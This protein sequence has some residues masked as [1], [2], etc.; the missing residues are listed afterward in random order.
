MIFIFL[1][2]FMETVLSLIHTSI[3]LDLVPAVYP[4]DYSSSTYDKYPL[5]PLL[6]INEEYL[7]I[8]E[9][10]APRIRKEFRDLS[11]EEWQEYKEAVLTIRKLKYLEPIARVHYAVR[12]YAHNSLE[13]LPWHRLFLLYYEYLLQCVSGNKNMT[14]PYWDWT[15]DAKRPSDSPILKEFYWGLSKCFLVHEPVTHCLKRTS[16][17][18]IDPFYKQ[19]DITRIIEKKNSF[20]EF[21]I[22]LELIPHALVHLNI[23]GQTGDMS[24]MQSTN[25]PLFWHHHSYVEYIW[26]QRNRYYTVNHPSRTRTAL[27]PQDKLDHI[28]YPFN[29]SVRDTLSLSRYIVYEPRRHKQNT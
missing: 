9:I 24:Y 10:K 15:V 18:R 8:P 26:E 22:E 27:Y 2:F 23:G 1:F 11:Q 6:S 3:P 29:I 4:S 21:T 17:P 5:N 19:A 12:G 14:V 20:Y 25:D 16:S 7:Y 13:F 28:L